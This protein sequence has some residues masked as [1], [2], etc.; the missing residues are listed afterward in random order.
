MTDIKIKE[1]SRQKKTKILFRIKGIEFKLTVFSSLIICKDRLK[2][3][4][5]RITNRT[6]L[7]LRPFNFHSLPVNV[8]MVGN[9][10]SASCNVMLAR[11]I[12]RLSDNVRDG[13]SSFVT[14]KLKKNQKATQEQCSCKVV[15][16]NREK[17]LKQLVILFGFV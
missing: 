4:F 13:N 14:I 8:A 12:G 7:A 11:P 17:S 6:P 9:V 16:C 15:S 3:I 5:I 10:A 2:F 1:N